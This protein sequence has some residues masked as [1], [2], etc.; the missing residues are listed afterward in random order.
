[1]AKEKLKLSWQTTIRELKKVDQ[2]LPPIALLEKY[3]AK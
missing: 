3:P 1:M 2:V